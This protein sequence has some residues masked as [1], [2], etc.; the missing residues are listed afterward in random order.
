MNF[1]MYTLAKIHLFTANK[2]LMN[3]DDY[4]QNWFVIIVSRERLSDLFRDPVPVR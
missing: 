2:A 3:G 1:A 4:V